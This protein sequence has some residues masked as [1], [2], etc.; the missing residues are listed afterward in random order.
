MNKPI[1]PREIRRVYQGRIFTVQV[2]T[3]RLPNGSELLARAVADERA[4]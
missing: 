4:A 3:V 1:F 2:E